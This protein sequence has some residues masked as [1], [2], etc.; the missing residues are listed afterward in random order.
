[1][2]AIRMMIV[3]VLAMMWVNGYLTGRDG[4]AGAHTFNQDWVVQNIGKL[5]EICKASG[6]DTLLSN[7]AA[8]L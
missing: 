3:L 1:M 4:D 7:A 8:K 6:G 5:T 2:P